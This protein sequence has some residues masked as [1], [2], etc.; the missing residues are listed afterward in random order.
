MRVTKLVREYIEESVDKALSKKSTAEIEYEAFRT[1]LEEFV[2]QV[3]NTVEQV[4]DE[5]VKNYR[6]VNHIPDDIEI[7]KTDYAFVR[8]SDWCSAI[9]NEA[10]AMKKK[11]NEAKARAIKDIMLTLELGG[12]KAD[13][14]VML[15]K[16]ATE[17]KI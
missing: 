3:Q 16:V 13:L 7:K 12:T 15:S 9:R 10:E 4:I 6:I 8:F 5:A 17:Y 1:E 11:R 14:D 2:E